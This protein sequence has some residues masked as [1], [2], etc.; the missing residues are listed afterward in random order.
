MHIINFILNNPVLYL[1]II[2]F[3]ILKVENRKVYPKVQRYFLEVFSESRL[4]IISE[5][6]E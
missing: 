1:A 6:D 2:K 5:M 3:I 4:L